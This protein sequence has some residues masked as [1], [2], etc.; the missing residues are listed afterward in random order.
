MLPLFNQYVFLN[1]FASVGSLYQHGMCHHALCAGIRALL[2]VCPYPHF[3]SHI[4]LK[5]NDLISLLPNFFFLLLKQ[6]YLIFIAQLETLFLKE[7]LTLH[8][9]CCFLSKML[10]HSSV[11][12]LFF[13]KKKNQISAFRQLTPLLYIYSP[14]GSIYRSKCPYSKPCTMLPK[15]LIDRGPEEATY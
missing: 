5:T 15:R 14:C 10:I 4:F 1:N 11:V 2:Q 7:D 6:R 13:K 9:R 12:L 8:V 3:S